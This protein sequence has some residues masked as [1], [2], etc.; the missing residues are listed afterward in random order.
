V[1][2]VTIARYRRSRRLPARDAAA[3][4]RRDVNRA[5]YVGC[6]RCGGAFAPSDVEVDHIRP[7][8]LGGEDVAGNIQILCIPCHQSKTREEFSYAAAG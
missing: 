1:A 6:N 5:A 8:A 7:I 3:R 4:A 2:P